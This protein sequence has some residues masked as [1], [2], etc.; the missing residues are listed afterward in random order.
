M[1]TE[2]R[3]GII[4]RELAN[5]LNISDT[6]YERALSAYDAL[7]DHIKAHNDSWDVEVFPQGSFELGTV[8]RPVNDEDEYDVD[9][10]VLIKVPVF[11]DPKEL[12]DV[13]KGFLE[14][15]G[16]YEGNIE[17]KKQ[18]LRI[19]YSESAQFHMDVVCAKP[20]I[21]D[22]IIDVA[23]KQEC[24]ATYMY[25]ESNPKGYINWFKETMNYSRLL[26]EAKQKRDGVFANTEVQELSLSKLRTPLQQ[27]VQIL[28]RHRDIYFKDRLDDRPS[29][30][31]ITT[32]CAKSYEH[33]KMYDWSHDNV[34]TVI[35]RMLELVP[36]FIE[37]DDNGDYVL[38]NPSL[39]SENFLYK[40][41][42]N[43]DLER[44]F[45]EWIRKATVDIVE[46]PERFL[47][48]DPEKAG[49][50]L[51]ESFG[52]YAMGKALKRFGEHIGNINT[53]GEILIDKHTRDISSNTSATSTV[54]P[55]KNT[56]YGG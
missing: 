40:W 9:M 41:K 2:H 27:A 28:K 12:R 52:S 53:K 20:I 21:D 10:V 32:L 33:D 42:S 15:H 18:C 24:S 47:P 36:C 13:I 35:K 23:K 49:E 29:S 4:Y 31:I 44:N 46:N 37:T 54:H 11:T 43:K 50:L 1:T 22:N 17:E 48:R 34:Y 39:E 14:Q 3:L 26:L 51:R 19:V 56:F 8:I 6:L 30:I 16:R 5:E 7:S 55:K 38:K 45:R 25:S